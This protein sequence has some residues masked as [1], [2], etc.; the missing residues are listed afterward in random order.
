MIDV[1]DTVSG[2]ALAL[3]PTSQYDAPSALIPQVP[4]AYD[5]LYTELVTLAQHGLPGVARSRVPLFVHR[6]PD[7]GHA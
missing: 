6:S 3:K 7:H 4:Q 2:V 5:E 1:R